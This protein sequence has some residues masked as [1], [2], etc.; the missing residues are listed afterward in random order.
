[1]NLTLTGTDS[2]ANLPSSC[3]QLNGTLTIN[4]TASSLAKLGD[5]RQVKDLVI[6]GGSLT[7]I[8]MSEG[9][10]VTAQARHRELEADVARE[11]HA[12]RRL[13]VPDLPRLGQRDGE[14]V[15]D[16]PRRRRAI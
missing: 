13:V 9:L 7:S 11:H 5:L 14:P 2:I 10:T 1:M 16:R 12:A 8:D 6:N 3:W 4:G 15:A